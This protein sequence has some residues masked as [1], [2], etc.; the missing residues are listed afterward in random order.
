MSK[1]QRLEKAKTQEKLKKTMS[2]AE[3]VVFVDYRGVNVADDTRLR[4]ICRDSAVEYKVVKNTL[5]GRA[6]AELGLSGLEEILHGPT[7]MAVSS[8]DPVGPA[9]VMSSF[10]REVPALH[11]K[12]GVLNGAVI[13]ADRVA[14]LATLPPKKQ[15]LGYVLGAF[16]SPM[17]AT[18][19]VLNATLSGFARA[20]D[21]IREKK[22]SA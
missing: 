13:T 1:K 21:A 6:A 15:L 5:T 16:Q 4:R 14:F 8:T 3:S 17:T 18:V 19:T 10:A 11:I 7:G 20:I 12:G 22:A 2:S 9:K